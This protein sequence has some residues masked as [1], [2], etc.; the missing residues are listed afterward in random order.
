VCAYVLV[1]VLYNRGEGTK[2]T[3]DRSLVKG[4]AE[5]RIGIGRVCHRAMNNF[6]I[7][8]DDIEI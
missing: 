6:G 3:M 7:Q 2:Y 1:I 5:K 4:S 8:L